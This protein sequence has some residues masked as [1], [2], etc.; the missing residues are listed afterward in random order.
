M[1][2]YCEVCFNDNAELKPFYFERTGPFYSEQEKNEEKIL[3]TIMNLTNVGY[4]DNLCNIGPTISI[5]GFKENDEID[6]FDLKI[7]YCPMCGRKL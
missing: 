3:G 6:W 2:E 7:N 1:C 5:K 4:G